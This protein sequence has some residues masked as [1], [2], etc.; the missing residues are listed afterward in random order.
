M[1][2]RLFLNTFLD[3]ATD[4]GKPICS[5][6]KQQLDLCYQAL[7]RRLRR[8][9]GELC[10]IAIIAW[11]DFVARKFGGLLYKQFKELLPHMLGLK[12]RNGSLTINCNEKTVCYEPILCMKAYLLC[13]KRWMK[14]ELERL[15][16]GT[17]YARVAR[18]VLGETAVPEECGGLPP[19]C[20]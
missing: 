12:R 3:A 7:E 5:K 11:M 4:M 1:K 13:K 2:P 19:E 9:D 17:P 6:T 14:K 20:R 8:E 18:V 15:E 16:P 10:R